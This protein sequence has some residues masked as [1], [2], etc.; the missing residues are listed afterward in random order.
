MV[1]SYPERTFSGSFELFIPGPNYTGIA[2]IAWGP[3]DVLQLSFN[4]K[5][6]LGQVKNIWFDS[7]LRTPFDGWHRNELKYGFYHL[8]N[9]LLANASV[10]W[11]N[12]QKVDLV[13]KNDYDFSDPH[14]RYEL[15]LLL[16]S[17][18]KEIPTINAIFNHRHSSNHLNT[19]VLL[20]HVAFNETPN[21]LSVMSKW[22]VSSNEEFRNLT[23]SV[24]LESSIEGYQTGVFGTRFSLNAE[25]WL[26][27]TADLHLENKKYTFRTEG[28]VKK[29]LDSMLVVNIT[30]PI[31]KYRDI[32]CRFGLNEQERHIL[33]A[34]N[35][36]LHSLGIEVKFDVTNQSNFDVK[37]HLQTLFERAKNILLIAKMKP[38]NVDFQGGWDEMQGGFVSIYRMISIKNFEYVWKFYTPLEKHRETSFVAKF[39]HRG[40]YELDLE[41]MF[42]LSKNK[43]GIM[44]NAK[45]KPK[46]MQILRL[47]R[48]SNFKRDLNEDED[49][50]VYLQHFQKVKE[51][52]KSG[53]E[54]EEEEDSNTAADDNNNEYIDNVITFT[55]SLELNTIIW[56]PIQ[57]VLDVDEINDNFIAF[58]NITIPQGNIVIRNNLYFPDLSNVRNLAI[59]STPLKVAKQIKLFHIHSVEPGKFHIFAEELSFLNQTD[60][61]DVGYRFNYTRHKEYQTE[62][63]LVDLSFATPFDFAPKFHL[64]GNLE[65]TVGPEESTSYQAGLR[66]DTAMS[67]LSL[68]GSADLSGNDLD[69]TARLTLNAPTVPEYTLN[70]MLKKEMSILVNSLKLSVE[71]VN[72]NEKIQ[73]NGEANWYRDEANYFRGGGK[74]QTNVFP[75][76]IAEVDL[77]WRKEINFEGGINLWY[78]NLAHTRTD[79][80][81]KTKKDKQQIVVQ[82]VTPLRDFTNVTIDVF[83]LPSNQPNRYSLT[84]KMFRPSDVYDI[85]GFLVF[86]ENIPSA[87]NLNL[88]AQ[89]NRGA[90]RGNLVYLLTNSEV[91]Y[92]KNVDIKIVEGKTFFE[93]AGSLS[94]FSKL[95]W[96][97]TSSIKTSPG[98]ISNKPNG[99]QCKFSASVT[100]QNNENH[101]ITVL[102]F[103][104]PW[105]HLGIDAV[106]VKND[107]LITPKSGN[108]QL[109]YDLSLVQGHV[110]S[111]WSLDFTENLKLMLNNRMQKIEH[112]EKSLKLGVQ[113]TNSGKKVKQLT[114]GGILAVNS[115]W[116]FEANASLEQDAL[117]DIKTG[118]TLHLPGGSGSD[119]DIHNFDVHYYGDIESLDSI[120]KTKNFNYDAKYS[121]KM[122][123]KK[124]SSQGRYRNETDLKTTLRA[125]WGTADKKNMIESNVQ[126]LRKGSK[127]EL[128]AN[129]KTPFYNN[130]ESLIATG[131]YDKRNLNH[132]LLL[133]SFIHTY[134]FPKT[135]SIS[136][137]NLSF[138]TIL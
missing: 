61:I 118:L 52:Y 45:P 78:E 5:A 6:I 55:G 132:I 105:R 108:A 25:K 26:Y 30:T 49:N 107:I 111:S 4:A 121:S 68:Y 51:M 128:L 47:Q 133:V 43:L 3:Q 73:F 58:A 7:Q 74:I 16:N 32:F 27:G 120:L 37:L 22:N 101:F 114:F 81:I 14:I 70:V 137:I 31:E 63:K 130:E 122:S 13:L 104:S 59:V 83:L 127:R 53:D 99:N 33:A 28:K 123:Q 87:A 92:G 36:P 1:F 69:V 60:W 75:I 90:A 23:G 64:N 97:L 135:L 85:D 86:T 17:L 124:F 42:K 119:A 34:V 46:M 12:D 91:G 138:Y 15:K 136:Y 100:P 9:L 62:L 89:R 29:I 35:T 8:N 65:T 71:E 19:D 11:A 48:L 38:D 82:L 18:V 94:A 131:S 77:Y 24:A 84:G 67:Q 102:N 50:D 98:L 2:N 125:D 44:M 21:L 66:T 109:F 113:Y 56:T 93:A 117:K 95:H 129:V 110:F 57:G 20:K 54:S 76:Q 88:V 80:S 103:T 96:T 126:I 79:F 116:R 106:N 40:T 72:D 10:L 112:E 134:S 39:I 115:K 41:L